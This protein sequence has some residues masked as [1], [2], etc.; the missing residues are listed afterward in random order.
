MSHPDG[1]ITNLVT[2]HMKAPPKSFLQ[3]VIQSNT[4]AWEKARVST[5]IVT[6]FFLGS[7]AG[8]KASKLA[9]DQ[10]SKGRFAPLFTCSSV[11]IAALTFLH[12]TL[13]ERFCHN[14][15]LESEVVESMRATLRQKGVSARSIRNVEALEKIVEGDSKEIDPTEEE[16]TEHSYET[17][18]V[19]QFFPS[20]TF[21]HAQNLQP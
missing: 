3:R 15:Q 16:E 8:G 13:C 9:L 5:I 2:N 11:V 12:F 1:I 10:Y 18:R 14:Y 17:G 20:N 21:R 6:S 4:K 7:L 19:K